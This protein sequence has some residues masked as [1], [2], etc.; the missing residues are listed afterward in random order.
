MRVYLKKYVILYFIFVFSSLKLEYLDMT[1]AVIDL[2]SINSI[3]KHCKMLKSLSLESLHINNQT[4]FFI[5]E[6]T[7]LTTLNLCMVEGIFA[8]GLILILS[9]L[10]K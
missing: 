8:D 5:S 2:D 10:K 6:N 7:N 4:L 3:L 1:N 9:S